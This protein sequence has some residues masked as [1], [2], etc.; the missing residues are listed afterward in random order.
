M[1]EETKQT[2]IIVGS[3]LAGILILSVAMGLLNYYLFTKASKK[4]DEDWEKKNKDFFN[5]HL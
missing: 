5:R 2:L 4:M 1:T 3:I